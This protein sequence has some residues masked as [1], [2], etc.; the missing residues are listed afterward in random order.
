MREINLTLGGMPPSGLIVCAVDEVAN[1]VKDSITHIVSIR[2][3]G[4]PSARPPWFKGPFLELHF[5]DVDSAEDAKACNS[6]PPNADHIR[7]A[8]HFS[9]DSFRSSDAKTLVFC[10]YGASRSPALAYV[11]LAAHFGP[12][13]EQECFE[14]IL[15]IRPVAIPNTYIIR[16]GDALLVRHGA[17]I[18]PNKNYQEKLF[19]GGDGDWKP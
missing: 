6:L 1:F 11:L 4:A 14:T 12:G 13:K 9:R 18:G 5:G 17:L 3:P 7:D 16:L 10:D 19:Q 15:A 2:N 8:I